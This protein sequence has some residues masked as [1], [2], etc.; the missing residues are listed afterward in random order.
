M[1]TAKQRSLFCKERLPGNGALFGFRP[2][3]FFRISDFG[4]RISLLVCVF[5][6]GVAA[7]SGCVSKSEAE[8]Q[9]KAAYLSG[10][11]EAMVQSQQQAQSPTV[12]V[13]GPVKNPI[14]PWIQGMNLSKALFDAGCFSNFNPTSIAIHRPGQDMDIDLQRFYAG[15]DYPVLPG[16]VIELR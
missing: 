8:L 16:D 4:L 9:A 5:L 2:S 13:I 12:R 14:V 7:L 1:K 10:Q 15:D 6:G 11:R 3:D